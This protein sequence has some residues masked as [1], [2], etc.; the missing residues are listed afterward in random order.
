MLLLLPFSHSRIVRASAARFGVS[1]AFVLPIICA[2]PALRLSSRTRSPDFGERGE[3]SAVSMRRLS[4]CPCSFCERGAFLLACGG[5][6]TACPP[7][8]GRPARRRFAFAF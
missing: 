1:F 2:C 6:P 5:L 7:V 4:G 8:A 3:G